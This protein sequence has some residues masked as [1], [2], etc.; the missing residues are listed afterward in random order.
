MAFSIP[1]RLPVMMLSQ[2]NLFP[3]GLLPLHLFEA[4]YRR[5]ITDVLRGERM[6]CI[7]T[8]M[9]PEEALRPEECVHPV[10]TAGFVRA[11]VA[12]SDGCSNLLLQ[13]V[14]R[15]RLSDFQTDLPYVTAAVEV[16]PT[17]FDGSPEDLNALAE[18]IRGQALELAES[19][20]ALSSNGHDFLQQLTDPEILGDLVAY[21][22]VDDPQERHPLL[23]TR[24]LR[25]RL[26]YLS[27]SLENRLVDQ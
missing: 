20:G 9:T 19:G 1:S 25:T 10:S 14:R 4:R 7:G 18:R 5:M 12:Q 23:E 2:C 15:I 16:I 17:E 6:F 13:G 24:C 26:E 11:C 3:H 8:L 21:H 27:R 22:F